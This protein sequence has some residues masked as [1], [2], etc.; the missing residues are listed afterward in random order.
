MKLPVIFNQVFAKSVGALALVAGFLLAA[1]TAHASFSLAKPIQISQYQGT[2]PSG[3]YAVTFDV[4]ST[5]NGAGTVVALNPVGF[6]VTHLTLV[7]FKANVPST[8]RFVDVT[9]G[10]VYQISFSSSVLANN[11]PGPIVPFSPFRAELAPA[12]YNFSYERDPDV[13]IVTQSDGSKLAET[14][15]H[16]KSAGVRSSQL[17][18]FIGNNGDRKSL[19]ADF[20]AGQT[21]TVTTNLKPNLNY[22]VLVTSAGDTELRYAESLAQVFVNADGDVGVGQRLPAGSNSDQGT[23]GSGT[24][25][26]TGPGLQMQ[27]F[28]GMRGTGAKPQSGPAATV[29]TCDPSKAV[30]QCGDGI[31]NNQDGK[32]D[33]CGIDYRTTKY[34]NGDGILDVEPDP[35][36]ISPVMST[37]PD[38]VSEYND[39]VS[40]Q[41]IPCTDN[42]TVNDVFRLINNIIAFF[43]KVLLI[44]IFIALIMYVGFKYITAQGKPGQHAMLK[45][46]VVHVVLGLILIL[47]AWIIVRIILTTVGYTDSLLFLE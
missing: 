43:F 28:V 34:P 7:D 4:V 25:G 10:E 9:P 14:T 31:D 37:A 20:S 45:N 36:C 23:G 19:P 44:P 27:P 17:V 1:P 38:R 15:F 22:T 12:S 6:P 33:F 39:S 16:I 41:I 21:V 2:N 32:A 26:A 47:S 30:M 18:H 24:T 42:C 40:S 5:V 35:S 46:L 13:V 29:N 3:T 11:R 8:V